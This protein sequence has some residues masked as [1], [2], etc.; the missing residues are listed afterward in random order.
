LL[1]VELD[2]ELV[3]P[4]PFEDESLLVDD[5]ESLLDDSL[6]VPFEV[7]SL[8]ADSLELELRFELPRLSVL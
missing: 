8:D 7:D 6:L 4:L 5:V 1:A 2:E 3:E